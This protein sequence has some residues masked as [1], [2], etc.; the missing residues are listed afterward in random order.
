MKQVYTKV[1]E[2]PDNIFW[3]MEK[4][5]SNKTSGR[6]YTSQITNIKI[7]NTVAVYSVNE[8]GEEIQIAQLAYIDYEDLRQ[9]YEKGEDIDLNYTYI[10][11]FSW[12]G[13]DK[14]YEIEEYPLKNIRSFNAR[15]SFWNAEE[16]ENYLVSL[17]QLS[18]ENGDMCFNYSIFFKTLMNLANI[19]VLKGGLYFD[20]SKF[21]ESELSIF[22]ASCSKGLYNNG[23]ISCNYTQYN[24]SKV[25]FE[26]I[27]NEL[28][29]SFLLADMANTE[30]R[31]GNPI[32]TIKE[33]CFIKAK[34]DSLDLDH[35]E[36]DKID[37]RELTANKISIFGCE[38]NGL[39]EIHTLNDVEM[40]IKNCIINSD[41]KLTFDKIPKTLEFDKTLNNGKIHIRN[42]KEVL[43]IIVSRVSETKDIEQ[44]LMLKENFKN[45]GQYISED[46][47][48][49]KYRQLENKF[50]TEKKSSKL[51]NYIN[52]L[53]SDYGTCPLRMFILI[54]IMI[55][56]FAILYFTCPYFKFE[57][58]TSFID[59]IY[60][61]GI[62]FFTVG[63][64]DILP[65]NELTKMIVLV[66]AFF[67][68]STMSYFLVVL[69]RKIIR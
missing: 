69:S 49:S 8:A 33:V 40:S 26:F 31:I 14:L 59:Y 41:T 2:N 44:L 67:G 35:C 7:I 47:C 48:Y 61:S 6:I 60:I 36:F 64:G 56:G 25:W 3:I 21:Y 34:I 18:I 22:G 27:R 15:C 54:I 5:I 37:A 52:W 4:E 58:A 42:F 28:D 17:L 46:L 50:Y 10:D 19:E 51:I 55:L 65:L 63:Y 16:K 45:I 13:T 38:F 23:I 66:Q 12:Y 32:G 9:K 24:N 53:V 43:P 30:L 68:V 29:I 57:N 11:N 62:T 39:V 20:N 1:I